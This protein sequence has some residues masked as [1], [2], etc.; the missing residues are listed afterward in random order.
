MQLHILNQ[1]YEITGDKNAA[2]QCLEIIQA[3]VKRANLLLD[4]LN[5]DGMDVFNNY[6]EYLS[7]KETGAEIV[8]AKVSTLQ[9]LLENLLVSAHQYLT[10]VVPIISNLSDRFYKSP[11]SSTWNDF[12]SLLAGLSWIVELGQKIEE[13]NYYLNLLEHFQVIETQV[14]ELF[15]AIKN[16]D[17]ILLGDL[18]KY[19]L[20]PLLE[21]LDKEIM[22][23]LGK[24]GIEF[25][26][27]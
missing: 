2:D 13:H 17:N 22:V 10:N 8:L 24:E 3:E 21:N 1:V 27:N 23:H 25:D 6:K 19:E 16:E 14:K 9:Q 11:E 12:D 4:H 18:I 5:V 20:A 7:D 26:T 15:D